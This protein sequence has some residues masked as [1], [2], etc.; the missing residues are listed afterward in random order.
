MLNDWNNTRKDFPQEL[1]LHQ[2]FESQVELSPHAPALVFD[3]QQITY[4]ELNCKANQLAHHLRDLGVGPETVVAVC[5][6]RSIEMVVGLLG[7]LKAGGAYLP[8]D[9][10]YPKERLAFMLNDAGASGGA[11]ADEPQGSSAGS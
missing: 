6:E 9:P 2:L 7:I 8:L 5:M 11:D 3:E 4:H 1:C 10:T